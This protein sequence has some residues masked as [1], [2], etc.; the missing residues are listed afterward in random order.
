M[1]FKW[2]WPMNPGPYRCE[3]LRS[4]PASP[5][6]KGEKRREGMSWE[7]GRVKALDSCRTVDD[8]VIYNEV[9][10]SHLRTH[11]VNWT[12]PFIVSYSFLSCSPSISV[13][14]TFSDHIVAKQWRNCLSSQIRLL[15]SR[16]D[17]NLSHKMTAWFLTR[18]WLHIRLYADVQ[19][20]HHNTI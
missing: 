19:I 6:I 14:L 11:A 7:R 2:V 5:L 13:F 20:V 16:S 1:L 10:I 12:L 8:S 15:Y 18:W 17:L 3:I 9:V 4:R